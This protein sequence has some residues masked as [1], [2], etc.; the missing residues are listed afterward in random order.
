MTAYASQSFQSS[1][2]IFTWRICSVNHKYLEVDVK[3]PEQFDFLKAKIKNYIKSNINRGR[4]EVVLFYQCSKS[5]NNQIT[6]QSNLVSNVVDILKNLQKKIGEPYHKIRVS[7]ILHFPGVIKNASFQGFC[8]IKE[9]I[10]KE[11]FLQT[12]G[13]FVLEKKQEG[14]QLSYLIKRKIKLALTEIMN[15]E[16][17]I[18]K[19]MKYQENKVIKIFKQKKIA[20]SKLQLARELVIVAQKND[21]DEEI[22]RLKI[23]FQSLLAILTQK[24]NQCIGRRLDFIVQEC[25]REANSIASKSVSQNLTFSAI[26]IKVLLEQIKEQIQNI[27]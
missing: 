4:V 19:V 2:G 11:L 14:E 16:N 17:T 12:I 9:S 7:E 5:E 24:K 18:P 27:E 15:I 25:N 22:N 6:L 20:I 26:N 10:A 23:H 21:I 8:S 13:N 1:I 3:I